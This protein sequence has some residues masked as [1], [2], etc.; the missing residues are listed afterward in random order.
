MNKYILSV[1]LFLFGC[2]TTGDSGKGFDDQI[3]YARCNLKYIKGMYIS[4]VNW[5]SSYGFIPA[6]KQLKV[7]HKGTAAT[8]MM[9]GASFK[10]KLDIGAKGKKFL[11]KFVSSEP[12]DIN[13]FT[14]EVQDNINNGVARIGMTK[15]EVYI[16]MGPPAWVPAGNTNNLTYEDIM[17]FDFWVYKR[18]TC[19]K[20]IGI[21]FDPSTGKANQT[22]GM[23]R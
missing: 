18:R 17:G 14:K 8:L 11:E 12:I 16:A 7:S 1:L 20:N 3:Y 22:Q 9:E 19:G 15:E 2:A 4:W 6:G 23:W 21:K 13:K 5:Q 10:Y